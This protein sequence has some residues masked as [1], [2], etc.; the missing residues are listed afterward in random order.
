M[1]A[2]PFVHLELRTPDP[3]R[4]CGFATHVFDWRPE[5]VHAGCQTYLALDCGGQVQGGIV[6]GEAGRSLWL[7]YV[8]TDDIR[9]ITER[10]RERGATV[11]VEVREGPAGWR[12]VIATPC[13]AEIGL[14]QPK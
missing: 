13:G 6:A 7:P 3:A 9:G 2:N 12:S 11:A 4:A 10:A 5:R 1:R 14:W 8:A